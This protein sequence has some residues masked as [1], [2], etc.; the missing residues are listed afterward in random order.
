MKQSKIKLFLTSN[1]P[2]TLTAM[3]RF[4]ARVRNSSKDKA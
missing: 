4:A 2:K 1:H 3:M